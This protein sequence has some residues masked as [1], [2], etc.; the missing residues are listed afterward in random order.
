MVRAT[1]ARVKARVGGSDPTSWDQTAIESLCTQ[2]DY[3]LDGY[4]Y[5]DTLST[6]DDL[7]IE[8]A[9]DMVMR[10]MRLADYMQQSSGSAGYEG[11]QYPDIKVLSDELK[12]RIDIILEQTRTAYTNVD[13][14]EED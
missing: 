5:P 1:Y 9:V 7:V 8:L 12:E 10:M 3:I 14:I 2:A 4:T 6:T 11:R 13:M